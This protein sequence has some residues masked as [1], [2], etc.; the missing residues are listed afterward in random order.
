M[1]C[2]PPNC[3]AQQSSLA[4]AQRALSEAQARLLAV[5]QWQKKV[6]QA[7]EAYRLRAHRLQQIARTDLPKAQASLKR[8][9]SDLEAYVRAGRLGFSSP[10]A[11]IL[12]I[13]VTGY[14]AAV[15]RY[16][17]RARGAAVRE[18]K[19]QEVALVQRTGRGTRLWTPAE[20]RLMQRKDRFPKGYEGH[21]INS[22][23]RFPG[24]A[25]NPDNIDFVKSRRFSREHILRHHGKFTNASSGRMFNRKSLLVQW[26]RCKLDPYARQ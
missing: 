24:L 26:A 4:A 25:H 16:L 10:W 12:P 15:G 21:H 20:L 7:V 14:F 18:A 13:L 3:S 19:K 22:V 8:R 2:V 9:V 17:N 23:E 5:E 6:Q 11:S 1:T